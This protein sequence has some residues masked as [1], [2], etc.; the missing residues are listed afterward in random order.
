MRGL[1]FLKIWVYLNVDGKNWYRRRVDDIKEREINLKYKVFEM[2]G[3]Y[4]I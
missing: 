2:V 4:G 1:L 3:K